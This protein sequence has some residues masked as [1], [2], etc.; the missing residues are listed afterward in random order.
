MYVYNILVCLMLGNQSRDHNRVH[1]H[2]SN[3]QHQEGEKEKN[4]GTPD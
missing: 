4:N 1:V 2:Y 3:I